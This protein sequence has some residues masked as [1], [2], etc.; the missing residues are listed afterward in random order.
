MPLMARRLSGLCLDPHV[1]GTGRAVFSP[2]TFSCARFEFA[3]PLDGRASIVFIMI[4][5]LSF[6][7]LL[8]SLHTGLADSVF[9]ICREPF[10]LIEDLRFGGTA[11]GLKEGGRVRSV[12]LEP[13][14]A[15]RAATS[16]VTVA[17]E[18]EIKLGL[19][20][21]RTPRQP[22]LVDWVGFSVGRGFGFRSLTAFIIN[23]IIVLLIKV[24][25]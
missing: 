13:D 14:L 8:F 20:W 19:A 2:N 7:Q 1:V 17:A 10:A 12:A 16:S 11:T 3:P 25:R 23:S 15:T 5:A 9:R 21:A 24:K 18:G 4:G 6:P 22:K